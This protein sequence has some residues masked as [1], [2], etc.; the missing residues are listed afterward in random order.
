MVTVGANTW[1]KSKGDERRIYHVYV[2]EMCSVHVLPRH[3][4]MHYSRGDGT[5]RETTEGPGFRKNN[6]VRIIVKR[7][8]KIK[9][10][11]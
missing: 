4:R 10:M 7:A 9:L 3:T 11:K 1:R 6:L 8:G 2:N 5:N